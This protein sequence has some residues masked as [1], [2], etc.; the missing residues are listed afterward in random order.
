MSKFSLEY[1]RANPFN[2]T[3]ITSNLREKERGLTVASDGGI[4]STNDLAHPVP[5]SFADIVG[6]LSQ[7]CTLL[8]VRPLHDR[9]RLIPSIWVT[10]TYVPCVSP[11]DPFV[12]SRPSGMLLSKGKGRK[13]LTILFH[14]FGAFSVRITRSVPP[15]SRWANFGTPDTMLH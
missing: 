1:Y 7:D 13:W 4:Q 9:S 11:I 3:V 6:F 15:V 2:P 12:R 10:S 14:G 8:I 5:P